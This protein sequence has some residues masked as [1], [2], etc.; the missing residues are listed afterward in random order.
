MSR[1]RIALG[2]VNPA[3]LPD[4]RAKYTAAIANSDVSAVDYA[5]RARAHAP[6]EPAAI[7]REVRRLHREHGLAPRDI[8]QAMRLD[9]A[10][11]LDAIRETA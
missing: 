2:D 9:L 5:T 1:R 4:V 11:V 6:S 8:A 7:A 10:T 3:L